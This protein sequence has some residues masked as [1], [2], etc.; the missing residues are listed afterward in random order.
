M[1]KSSRLAKVPPI[2]DVPFEWNKV[3]DSIEEFNRFIEKIEYYDDDQYLKWSPED[4]IDQFYTHHGLESILDDIAYSSGGETGCAGNPA[5]GQALG[6]WINS[7]FG[8]K[9]YKKVQAAHE[10]CSKSAIYL[11]RRSEEASLEWD[12]LSEAEKKKAGRNFLQHLLGLPPMM[13]AY[14]QEVN[15][16]LKQIYPE[17]FTY[18]GF[19]IENPDHLAKPLANEMLAG[20]DFLKTFF[21]NRGLLPILEKEIRNFVIAFQP[22]DSSW[23]GMYESEDQTITLFHVLV[24]NSNTTG[25]LLKDWVSEVFLHEF[26]HHIH[27]KYI[28]GIAKEFW[29]SWWDIINEAKGI[30]E[31][32][33][34]VTYSERH[35]FFADLIEQDYHPWKVI[36]KYDKEISHKDERFPTHILKYRFR[37]W[38]NNPSKGYK[39]KITKYLNFDGVPKLTK[40]GQDIFSYF[41]DPYEYIEEHYPEVLPEHG[42]DKPGTLGILYAQKAEEIESEFKD[43]LGLDYRKA[44]QDWPIPNKAQSKELKKR[45]IKDTPKE[46]I[47]DVL[48]LDRY[49]IPSNY[50]TTNEKEDFAETFVRFATNP[51]ALSPIA[52]YRMKR[53]LSLSGLY[54]KPVMTFANVVEKLVDNGFEKEAYSI[55]YGYLKEDATS[56]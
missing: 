55:L 3:V 42:N 5:S 1:E 33:S 44:Q 13:K 45:A 41:E 25:R 30:E 29:D 27:M 6:F 53:T 19:R 50:G 22:Y 47:Q 23:H 36:K 18:G 46:F 32:A 14:A 52:L 4:V 28:H 17:R 34:P 10:P 12:N 49:G 37:L 54:G 31:S 11:L 43:I 2:N 16:L 38:L 21:K 15:A 8:Y 48:S 9:V 39:D 7:N 51:R 24:R 56:V 35:T 26:G 20:I 40:L